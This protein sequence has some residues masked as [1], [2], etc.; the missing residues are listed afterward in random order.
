MEKRMTCQKCPR[1][2]PDELHCRDGK[3]NPRR[4]SD[5]YA[6]VESLG[7]QALCH[8]NPYREPMGFRMYFPNGSGIAYARG[9]KDRR[10]DRVE[11]TIQKV[12]EAIQT[13]EE[14]LYQ[15]TISETEPI[16]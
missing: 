10:N 3:S 9:Y 4:K 16:D 6:V 2:N 13:S 7:L 14:D 8:Y 15:D 12:L 1:Y 5:V 11:A